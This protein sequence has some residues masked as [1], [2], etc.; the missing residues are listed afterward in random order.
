MVVIVAGVIVIVGVVG[1]AGMASVMCVIR[2][3]AMCRLG[4]VA[5]VVMGM[6]CASVVGLHGS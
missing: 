4:G 1:M 5:V 3:M 2:V 6:A